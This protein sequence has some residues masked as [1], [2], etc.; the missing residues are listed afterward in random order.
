MEPILVESTAPPPWADSQSFTDKWGTYLWAV[1]FL[2]LSVMC[3]FVPF[4][5]PSI[6]PTCLSKCF[7]KLPRDAVPLSAEEEAAW[8]DSLQA[9]NSQKCLLSWRCIVNVLGH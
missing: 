6:L 5:M 7:G 1:P 9:Q 4:C 2:L 8:V 3:C